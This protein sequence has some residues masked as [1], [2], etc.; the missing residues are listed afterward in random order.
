MQPPPELSSTITTLEAA[1]QHY[2][3]VKDDKSF[4]EAFHEAGRGLPLVERALRGAQ[5]NLARV[6]Q[7]TMIPLE[8]CN[9][10]A[11]ISASIF[12]AVAQGPETSR[13]ERHKAAVRQ[14]GKGSTVEVLVVG[15]MEDLCALAEN[16]AIQDQVMGL[17]EAIEKLSN[18]EPSLPKEESGNT[19]THSGSG[20]IFNTTGGILN[21]SRGSGHHLPGAI[22]HAP[23]TFGSPP[24]P[25]SAQ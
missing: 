10:N 20:D 14:E 9:A 1:T 16:Y 7:S 6:P 19:F 5:R 18:M 2:N 23:V 25:G 15:M 22:F 21:T 8:A 4:R 11:K 13:F 12:K 17:R 24:P 3:I